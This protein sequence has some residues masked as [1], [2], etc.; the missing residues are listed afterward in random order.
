MA[1]KMIRDLGRGLEILVSDASSVKVIRNRLGVPTFA[2]TVADPKEFKLNKSARP[3]LVNRPRTGGTS[4]DAR[5]QQATKIFDV[6]E[7]SLVSN[8]QPKGRADPVLISK[9]LDAMYSEHGLS[10]TIFSKNSESLILG[11]KNLD[12]EVDT[13]LDRYEDYSHLTK[14]IKDE[15]T[16]KRYLMQLNQSKFSEFWNRLKNLTID[17]KGIL[18]LIFQ[19]FKIFLTELNGCT[20]TKTQY[21][22]RIV[23]QVCDLLECEK[24]ILLRSDPLNGE[25]K[26]T[27]IAGNDQ[28]RINIPATKGICDWV[29]QTKLVCNIK[30]AKND[31]RYH[32]SIDPKT[33]GDLGSVLVVPILNRMHETEGVI[34]AV[35]KKPDRNNF[36]RFFSKEDQEL[37]GMVAK[38]LDNLIE[39]NSEVEDQTLIHNN[40]RAM[41]NCGVFMSSIKD[42]RTLIVAAETKL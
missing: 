27:V 41:L 12:R 23:D 38:I 10:S 29:M 37:L 26:S 30:E 9:N 7:S 36:T 42:T 31:E 3:V 13:I 24:A 28:K 35:G 14:L 21:M 20:M 40:F 33:C 16:F 17:V 15:T 2:E 34:Q 6:G 39:K 11:S 18:K 8:G 22:K 5:S 19:I 4:V 1:T 32:K 25:L